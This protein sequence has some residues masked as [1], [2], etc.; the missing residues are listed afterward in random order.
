MAAQDYHHCA[1]I[2]MQNYIKQ[3][4]NQNKSLIIVELL[5]IFAAFKSGFAFRL[6]CMHKNILRL[7]IDKEKRLPCK[8]NVI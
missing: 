6:S 8:Y 7:S 1:R 4:K 3:R 2:Y 5:Y